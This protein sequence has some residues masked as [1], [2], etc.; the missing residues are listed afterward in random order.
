MATGVA[1][2]VKRK[3]LPLQKICRKSHM[4]YLRNLAAAVAMFGLTAAF[5]Q[6]V[7][8]SIVAVPEESGIDFMQITSASDYVCLPVVQRSS[9]SLNWMTNRVLDISVDGTKIAY[10]SYRNDTSNIFIKEL[11]KQGASVQRTNRQMVIDFSFSPDGEYICFS[12]QRGATTQIFR[13]SAHQGYICR[14]LTSANRDYSPVYSDDMKQVLFARQEANSLS[15]WGYDMSNNFLSSYTS[16]MNPCPLPEEPAFLC[17]RVNSSGRT[18]IW[19]VNYETGVEECVI[20]D[21]NRSFSSPSISPNGKWI[22]FVGESVIDAGSF[23]YRNTD[24]FACRPDGSDIVQL[25]YHAADDLS[26]E[27]SCNSRYIFFVSQRG[28]TDGT[29]NIWRMNFLYQ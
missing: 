1:G 11:G 4:R 18:E 22:L 12:E 2:V 17:A 25:T 3:S 13:T 7:D 27:W 6:K 10:L 15:I 20:S 21:P 26:P 28:S 29:A 5:A 9:T 16:G 19:K 23:T 14:Q 8:Y 24:I